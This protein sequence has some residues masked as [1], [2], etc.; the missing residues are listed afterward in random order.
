MQSSLA[1]AERAFQLLDQAPDVE[2]RVDAQPLERANGDIRFEEVSFGYDTSA[3]VLSEVS[4]E[5]RSGERIGVY[6]VNGAGKTPL[7]S[8]LTR[9]CDPNEGGILLEGVDIP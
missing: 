3:P 7:S 1:S 2:E 9:F 5:L 6:G 8:R 4:L